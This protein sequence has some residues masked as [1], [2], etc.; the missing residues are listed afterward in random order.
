MILPSLIHSLTG[1]RIKVGRTK[2]ICDMEE[3]QGPR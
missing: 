2:T 3:I 1:N